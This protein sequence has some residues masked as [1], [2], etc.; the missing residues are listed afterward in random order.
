MKQ[1]FFTAILISVFC[2]AAFAQASVKKDSQSNQSPKIL[3]QFNDTDNEWYKI[4]LEI[5]AGELANNKSA[6]GLIRIKNDDPR[7]FVRRFYGLLVKRFSFYELDL[8]RLR[9]L[10]VDKQEHDT[11]VLVASGCSEI[12][13]CEGCIVIRALDIGKISILPK[14]KTTA[15][16]RKKK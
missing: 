11:D 16:R 12:P 9:F 7:K 6:I 14:P 13:K 1:T 4:T 2:I 5:I 8:S 15:K 10:I 3:A